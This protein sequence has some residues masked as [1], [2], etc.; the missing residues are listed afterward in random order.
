MPIQTFRRAHRPL[1]QHAADWQP[2]PESTFDALRLSRD[3]LEQLARSFR[4]R[5]VLPGMPE[6]D[7]D[8]VSNPL[9]DFHPVALLYCAVPGD[10]ALALQLAR[11][12]RLPFTCRSGGH[13]TAGFSVDDGLVIDVSLMRGI[14]I[15][16]DRM[17]ARVASGVNFGDLNAVLD[18]HRLHLPGGGCADV[19]IAGY[20]QGG[21]YGFTSREFGMN[22]D[23]V[24]G[25]T[26]MLADGSLVV[27]DDR[28]NR[29]LFWAARGG[30]GNNFGVLLDV[31]YRL[32]ALYEVW[33]FGLRWPLAGAPDALL[34]LQQAYMR[35]GAPAALGFQA[36]LAE[37]A[38]EPSLNVLGM[39]HGP[40]A[41]GLAA[42]AALRATGAPELTIDRV[43]TYARLNDGLLDQLTPPTGDV[44]EF[45]RSGYLASPLA[46]A[47]WQAL[48]DAYRR[49]PSRF[50]MIG[51]E[52]Y[53]AAIRTPPPGGNAFVHRDVDC[54]LF[55]D[56]FFDASGSP[57]SREAAQSWLD[58]TMALMR[59]FL[60]GHV[61]QNYPVRGLPGFRH[62][63]WG[64]AFEPLLA[65]KRKYDPQ[66][67]F[68][69]EQ[70]LSPWPAGIE[71]PGTAPLDAPAGAAEAIERVA[72]PPA[73]H[74]VLSAGA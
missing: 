45:K 15:D 62:A 44:V 65:V 55:I 61:Y 32:H 43:D 25:V 4:G 2:V 58:D 26:L 63:Y 51:F 17:E 64:A 35:E 29:D 49:A 3:E 66:D 33:G 47:D 21:G 28:R 16:R 56:S 41:E 31:R 24:L 14:A 52:P 46:R 30:T 42:I 19:G 6:Y 7:T 36:F 18:T 69:F 27:A 67:V 59:P 48:V 57:T 22:C 34:L 1:Q 37:S 20:M 50:A 53:G 8:R 23:N 38:G 71:R 72:P 5:I 68:H 60:N 10:V 12:A 70:S 11:H 54:D 9:F 40:R 73:L 74:E 39:F 13:S